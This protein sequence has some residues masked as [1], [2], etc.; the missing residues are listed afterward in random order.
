MALLKKAKLEN[1]KMLFSNRWYRSVVRRIE[2][3]LVEE[4]KR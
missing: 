3:E 2:K 4:E 1:S